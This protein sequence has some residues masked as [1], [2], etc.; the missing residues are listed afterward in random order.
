MTNETEHE[1]DAVKLL[2]MIETVDPSDTAKL[3]EIDARVWCFL[4][5]R[6]LRFTEGKRRFRY[7]LQCPLSMPPHRKRLNK[8]EYYTRSRNALKAIRP[9]VWSIVN[10]AGDRGIYC[11]IVMDEKASFFCSCAKTEELAELHAIIQAIAY[12]R[13]AFSLR[14]AFWR[15]KLYRQYCILILS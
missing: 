6:V 13:G 5:D 10:Q 14:Y 8:E 9:P 1:P 11:N 12:E 3:D 15:N 2:Q 7:T 4:N